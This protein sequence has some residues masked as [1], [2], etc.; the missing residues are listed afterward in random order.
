MA[1]LKLIV[2]DFSGG[3]STLGEKK[4]IP[5]SAKFSKSLNP[6]IDPS[7]IVLSRLATKKSSTTVAGLPLW[8]ED[9]SPYATDRF[10]YD[11]AG[12]IYKVTSSDVFSLLRTVSGSNGE[13]LR[14][15]DDFLF[16][17]TPT[18]L[19]RYG[20]LSGTPSFNDDFLSDGNRNADDSGGG[21]GST[22]YTPP[23]SISET[24]TNRQTMSLTKDP[25]KSITINLDVTGSGDMTL[26]VHDIDNILIGSATIVNGSLVVG[27]NTFVFST[28]LRI[29]DTQTY[30]LHI[31]ST[32]A[33]GGVDTN[34]NSDL[35]G[36]EYSTL[37]GI[38]IDT[39]FH[40]MVQQIR[41]LVIGNENYIATWNGTNYFPNRIELPQG[42]VVRA[43]ASTNEFVVIEAFKGNS[44]R[45]AEEAIRVY[46]DGISSAANFT[47]RITIG[48][49]NALGT[50]QNQLVGVF[51]HE[52]AVYKGDELIDV[53][54]KIPKLATGK[55]VEVFPGAIT[56]F[57]GR[58]LIGYAGNTDDTSSVELG[59]YEHG[60]QDSNLPKVLNLSYIVSTNDTQGAN[61]K[62]GMVKAIGQDIYIGAQ[63]GASTY[64]VSKVALGD[65]A[66]ASGSWDSLIFDHGNAKRDK[67]AISVELTFEALTS[68]QSVTP[69]YK[70]DRASSFTTDIVANTVGDTSVK[71][72]INSRFKEIEFG[73]NLASTNNTFIK[74]TG[75]ILTFDPLSGETV[76]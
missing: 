46:W 37:F 63:T 9:A 1:E 52:G 33:D 29:N 42:F 12:K 11:N 39:T 51:G 8:M 45:E 26:T 4:S 58:T 71:T 65:S 32:V 53:Y 54:A 62:I 28:P 7:S 35:E 67:L 57:N 76:D 47:T 73:F 64:E 15:F 44:V 69:K 60:S 10:V 20:K 72:F 70:I 27:D 74:I 59:I 13:G 6:F 41:S 40:P 66:I 68:G 2:Q 36:A 30:H 25:L 75:I 43:I 34:V 48:A 55:F 31:T 18:T 61:L 50:T 3:L 19:G 16:Y 24:A 21:T 38:L 22:D 5:N 49:C 17:A 56:E 23:T 14:V